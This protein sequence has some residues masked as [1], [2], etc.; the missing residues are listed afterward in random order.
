MKT[1]EITRSG[2]YTVSRGDDNDWI[3]ETVIVEVRDMVA[4]TYELP[5]DQP[6]TREQEEVFCIEPGCDR[7]RYRIKYVGTDL[8]DYLDDFDRSYPDAIWGPRLEITPLR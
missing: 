7:L 3:R 2:Y 8:D 4:E 5:P 6:L 1:S